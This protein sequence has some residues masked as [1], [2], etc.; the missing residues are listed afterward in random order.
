MVK[1]SER[2]IYQ[3]LVGSHSGT[4][5]LKAG[6]FNKKSVVLVKRKMDLLKRSSP[7]FSKVFCPGDGFSKSVF[8]FY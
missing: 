8:A 4:L 7:Y 2:H 6:N 1:F 5:A 3:G